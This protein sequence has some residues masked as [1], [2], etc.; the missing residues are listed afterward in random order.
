MKLAQN[1]FGDWVYYVE[2]LS[3]KWL[4][5]CQIFN[6]TVLVSRK[7]IDGFIVQV[8]VCPTSES[9]RPLQMCGSMTAKVRKGLTKSNDTARK[10]FHRRDHKTDFKNGQVTI[11]SHRIMYKMG[12]TSFEIVSARTSSELQCY[13]AYAISSTGIEHSRNM[14]WKRKN[15]AESSIV[16]NQLKTSRAC[17]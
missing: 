4:K 2:D 6:L 8:Q 1:V 7:W 3:Q 14:A 13:L 5:I 9:S 17:I 11:T 10:T 16:G 15:W 12:Q